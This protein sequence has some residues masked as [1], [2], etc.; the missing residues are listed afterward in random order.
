MKQ[1]RQRFPHWGRSPVIQHSSAPCTSWS[2]AGSLRGQHRKWRWDFNWETDRTWKTVHGNL[3]ASVRKVKIQRVQ[4]RVKCTTG[5]SHQILQQ[6]TGIWRWGKT[7]QATQR[8]VCAAQCPVGLCFHCSAEAALRAKKFS[9][10]S[11]VLL[12]ITAVLLE[13]SNHKADLSFHS[14]HHVTRPQTFLT[15]LFYC[16]SRY[17]QV[18]LSIN[19]VI[20][21]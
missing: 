9:L 2:K 5:I 4:F 14:A 1:R 8:A 16:F 20:F 15:S 12:W 13:E 6:Q 17:F 11:P 10:V 21:F 19:S 18:C 3:Q 7:H